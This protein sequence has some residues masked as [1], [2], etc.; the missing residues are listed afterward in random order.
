MANHF[1]LNPANGG[2]PPKFNRLK[3]AC[4]DVWGGEKRVDSVSL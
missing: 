1:S 2:R 3:V 4:K